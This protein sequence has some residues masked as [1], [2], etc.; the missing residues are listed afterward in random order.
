MHKRTSLTL[1]YDNYVEV[2][3]LAG[4]G[5]FLGFEIRP[6]QNGGWYQGKVY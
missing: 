1:W 6:M 4:F 2:K 5:S 3:E